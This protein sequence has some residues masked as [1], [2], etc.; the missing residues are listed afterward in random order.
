MRR[1]V[2]LYIV[3]LVLGMESC[4]RRVI[5]TSYTIHDTTSIVV[6]ERMVDTFIARD[7]VNQVIEVGCDSLNTPFVKGIGIKNGKRSTL[8][9]YF[10]HSKLHINSNC[11]A[12]EIA[13]R[14][15]DSI[16]KKQTR[17]H[18]ESKTVVE[19]GTGFWERVR[20]IIYHIGYTIGLIALWE[21]ILKPFLK[22]IK[23]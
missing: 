1:I 4:N 17:A 2:A 8:T 9:S 11:E 13:L 22:P 7:T 3:V 18:K 10:E 23:K 21:I 14:V 20:Q 19:K 5:S 15:Q 12:L 16:I 6:R